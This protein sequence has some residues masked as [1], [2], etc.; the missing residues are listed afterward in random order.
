MRFILLGDDSQQDPTIYS[1]VV[2]QF[3]HQIS[4]V[5]IRRI[6][7]DNRVATESLI[8]QIEAAGVPC[9]YFTHSE[10]ARQH[11]ASIGLVAS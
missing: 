8:R 3:C 10:E 7:P 2:Q 1:S 6:E 11:S 5:Y 9:C 4:C